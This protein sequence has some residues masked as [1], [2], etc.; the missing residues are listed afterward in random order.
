MLMFMN[1]IYLYILLIKKQQSWNLNVLI[2]C[3]YEFIKVK[4]R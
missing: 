1:I 3:L 4:I 2:D